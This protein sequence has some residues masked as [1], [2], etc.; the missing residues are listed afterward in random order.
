MAAVATFLNRNRWVEMPRD[1]GDPESGLVRWEMDPEGEFQT[2]LDGPG[3]VRAFNCGFYRC[4][5]SPAPRS[6][7][8]AYAATLTLPVPCGGSSRS[9]IEHDDIKCRGGANRP[10]RFGYS[11]GDRHSRT[12]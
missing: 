10:P 2:R 12:S 8:R 7:T 4:L 11:G 5:P 1:A 9:R 3:D 6:P